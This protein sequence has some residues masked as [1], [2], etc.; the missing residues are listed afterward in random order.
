MIK[1]GGLAIVK[2]AGGKRQLIPQLEK[3]FPKNFK[4]YHELFVGAGSVMLYL[5]QTKKIK[6]VFISDTNEE[7]INTY[8][9]IKN[10]VGELIILLKKYQQKHSEELYYITRKEDPEVM[11]KISRAARFIYL[12]RTCFNGLYRVNSKGQFNVPIGSYKNPGICQ[13][14]ELR[15]ISELLKSVNIKAQS[16]E[17]VLKKAKKEDFIYFDPPYYPLKKSSFTTYSKDSFLD[18]EQKDL[19]EIFKKLDKKGCLVMHSNSD[20]KFIKDLYRD[21]NIHLVYA[22]RNINSVSSGRRK[23]KEVVITNY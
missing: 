8:E 15:V 2:W 14:K 6:K 21:Y 20:T 16:F 1:E 10:S 4:N 5:K 3:L 19:F 12:N 23:I 18:K 17:K 22:R 7:L 13:E 9:V 11:S